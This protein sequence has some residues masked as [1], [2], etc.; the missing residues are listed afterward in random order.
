MEQ[1]LRKDIRKSFSKL[2][3]KYFGGMIILYAVQILVSNALGMLPPGISENQSIRFIIIMLAGYLVAVPAI[4]LLVRTPK[5][6][7]AAPKK[8]ISAGQWMIAFFISLGG[9]YVCN[10][11][12][13]GI[14]SVIGFI[15]KG[16]VTN[17]L[18]T[19][20]GNIGL[21]A[22][23]LIIVV[24]APIVEELIFRKLLIDRISKY[25]ELTA[26]LVSALMFG[27]YHANLNQFVYAFFMGCFWAFLYVKTK[28][29]ISVI[30]LHISINFMG[31]FLSSFLLK[32]C[33]YQKLM[34]VA[35]SGDIS[36]FT[37]T[38]LLGIF[39][40]LIYEF[41]L[42]AAIIAGIVLL[43][44]NRKKF[45]VHRENEMIPKGK[46]FQTAILNLGMGLYC[47]FFLVQ[48]IAQLFW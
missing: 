6:E 41:I 28:N 40:F 35:S 18:G 22:N 48:I 4:F 5:T 31:S 33:N 29:I 16:S 3:I 2:G 42:F 7:S 15:K 8:K 25:G 32:I 39:G 38:D 12:G 20:A 9:T 47:L 13:L 24:C 46:R 43:I 26:I 37:S 44:V 30:T 17:V 34:E 23:L 21:E 45:T 10:F 1:N 36:A 14:I 11:I 27:L 19:V